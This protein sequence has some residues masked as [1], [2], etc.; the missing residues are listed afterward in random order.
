MKYLTKQK[1]QSKLKSLGE[2]SAGERICFQRR[3]GGGGAPPEEE[4]RGG[5]IKGRKTG[6]HRKVLWQSRRRKKMAGTNRRGGEGKTLSEWTPR[7]FVKHER[8]LTLPLHEKSV[9]CL[10]ISMHESS[11]SQRGLIP[12]LNCT[13]NWSLTTNY[14][15]ELTS[16]FQKTCLLIR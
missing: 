13:S 7:L 6:S 16:R 15:F 14:S 2:G 3:C 11:Y 4:T 5:G 12:S 1:L 9:S 8:D 10:K